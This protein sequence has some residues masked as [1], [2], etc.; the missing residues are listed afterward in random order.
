VV[1]LNV[2]A[3]DCAPRVFSRRQRQF[4]ELIPARSILNLE[5]KYRGKILSIIP[6]QPYVGLNAFRKHLQE[7]VRRAIEDEVKR[8]LLVNIIPI[9]DKIEC[10]RSG[11]QK[12]AEDYNRVIE[13][14]DGVG[15]VTV[16]DFHRLMV[17]WGGPDR[18]TIDSMHMKAEGH[19]LLA[20][21]L[22]P[23]VRL[24]HDVRRPESGGVEGAAFL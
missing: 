12:L 4:L 18:L 2:G 14:F 8:L 21:S 1:L 13:E 23:Y 7:V 22:V 15:P 24:S 10:L 16:F 6:G 11:S 19:R 20:E 17:A 9:S 5:Q 3:S